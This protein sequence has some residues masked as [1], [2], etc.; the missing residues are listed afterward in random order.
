MKLKLISLIA[1]LGLLI[2]AC[3]PA[4]APAAAP[5]AP[6]AAAVQPTAAP[7]QPTPAT[8]ATPAG[9]AAPTPEFEKIINPQPEDWKY[10]PDGAAVTFIE[11]ADFQCPYCSEVAPLLKKLAD[12]YPKDVQIVYRHFPLPTHDKSLI[13]AEAPEAAGAQGKFWEMEGLLYETQAEW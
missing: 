10:G 2:S 1:L 3:A 11:W 4:T 9:T 8:P 6:D 12:A 13:T 5:A 7:A